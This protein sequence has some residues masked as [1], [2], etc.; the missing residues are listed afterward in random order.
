LEKE[1]PSVRYFTLR[2]LLGKGETDSEVTKAK[3]AIPDSKVAVKI[4][5]K[6]KAEGH[7]ENSDHPYNPKYKA[8]YWQTMVLGH[9]GLDKSNAKVR[10]AFELMSNEGEYT[11]II[12]K[13]VKD[14][15][16]L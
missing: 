3:A 6:Q 5:L 14:T 13:G 9:L 4:F 16:K 7:W 10:K 11:Q 15:A 8:T 2:D 12:Q 1:N